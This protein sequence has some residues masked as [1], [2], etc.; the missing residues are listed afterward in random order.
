MSNES[1]DEA[2]S[3]VISV[4]E[5]A[6]FVFGALVDENTTI[7]EYCEDDAFASPADADM[8]LATAVTSITSDLIPVVVDVEEPAELT[9]IRTDADRLTGLDSL[10]DRIPEATG[11]YLLVNTTAGGWKRVRH[12]DDG[13]FTVDSDVTDPE[14]TRYRVASPL[15]DEARG[16]IADLPESVDGEDIRVVDWS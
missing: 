7:I 2:F 11:Y 1:G 16:R 4:L 13:Q 3:A 9:E 15:V 10:V 8:A 5:D 6:R 14:D 12:V